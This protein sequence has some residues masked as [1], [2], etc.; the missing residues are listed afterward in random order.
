M[1]PKEFVETY[2]F[3]AVKSQVI[4]G[5]PLLVTLSQAALES[6]WGKHAN[7]FNFF[8][9]KAG[10]SW[11]GETQLLWTREY[12][13]KKWIKVQ[14]EFRKYPYPSQS[15][16]D[17]GILIKK[18]WPKAF[19]YSDPVGFIRSIQFDHDKPYATDPNYVESIQKIV[20]MISNI[21]IKMESI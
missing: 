16:A 2:L 11:K 5:V 12:E 1:T 9:I 19:S 17:H 6:G 8:G 14:A 13:N 18:R 7:G 3:D 20:K 15:F 21:I 4:T 10:K